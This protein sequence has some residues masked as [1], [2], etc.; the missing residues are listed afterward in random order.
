MPNG[1]VPTQTGLTLSP[2]LPRG[3][4]SRTGLTAAPP[5]D[6]DVDDLAVSGPDLT[7]HSHVSGRERGLLD[8]QTDRVV[9][10]ALGEGIR[11]RAL[12]ARPQAHGRKVAGD[13]DVVLR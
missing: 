4:S 5:G 9:L 3:R 2:V 6:P 13:G 11:L 10:A 1:L 7:I 12:V 8:R